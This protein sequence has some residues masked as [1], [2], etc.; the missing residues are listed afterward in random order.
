M[1]NKEEFL[2]IC[3]E[4][5]KRPGVDKLLSW[6]EKSDFYI[7]PASSRFHGDY[8]GGLVDHHL[9]VYKQLKRLLAAYPEVQCSD[10]TVA[11]IA[12]FHD[13]CKVNMY[14]VEKRNKKNEAGQWVS[15]DAFTIN[16]KFCYGGHGSKS[17]F[18]IM[19]F[20]DLSTEE[21]TAINCHMSCW[22]GNK[23]V[24]SAYAQCHLAW[25]LHAADEA[26]TYMDE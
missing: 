16:E 23:D 4:N 7:A 6:L 12:L 18:L 11:V 25:L 15:Y 21:A 24:G 14:T 13:L 8:A 22:D 5:I 17:V 26:A 2:S 20:M 3:N 19:K 1:T 9:H 10:E